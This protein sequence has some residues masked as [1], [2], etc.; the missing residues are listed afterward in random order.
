M[1]Y[2]KPH[3]LEQAYRHADGRTGARIDARDRDQAVARDTEK[4]L[5]R[6]VIGGVFLPGVCG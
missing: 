1:R 4:A 3:A 2:G 6:G 5:D